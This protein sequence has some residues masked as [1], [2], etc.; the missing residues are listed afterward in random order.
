MDN[1][2]GIWVGS[3]VTKASNVL[4]ALELGSGHQ[5]AGL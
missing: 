4:V 2:F 5:L 1:R 3:V